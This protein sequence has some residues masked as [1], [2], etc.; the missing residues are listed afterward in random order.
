MTDFPKFDEFTGGFKSGE[1]VLVAGRIG[2]GVHHLTQGFVLNTSIRHNN[3]VGVFSLNQSR[4]TYLQRLL[5]TE[6]GVPFHH[7]QKNTLTDNQKENL[8]SA[9]E[10]IA[11][12]QIFITD[13]MSFSVQSIIAE[14]QERVKWPEVKL[15]VIHGFSLLT[16][17]TYS[18]ITRSEELDRIASRLR[19]FA[20]YNDVSFLI[21]H[22]LPEISFQNYNQDFCPSVQEIYRDLSVAKYVDLVTVLYRPEYYGIKTW[23]FFDESTECEAELRILKNRHGNLDSFR[24]FFDSYRSR[25]N[26]IDD[27]RFKKQPWVAKA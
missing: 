21:T 4:D 9:K 2:M 3:T 13:S 10:L 25:F 6:A 15:F 18:G 27:E 20:I 5:G 7:L 14:A 8:K 11:K 22:E 26:E 12:A 16:D 17:N 1:L 24:L 19:D 23:P